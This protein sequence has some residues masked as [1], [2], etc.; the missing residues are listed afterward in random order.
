M[1]CPCN[2]QN[3]YANCCAI[4]HKNINQVKSAEQLMRS[5]YSAFAL[6][7]TEYLYKSHHST[8]RPSKKEHEEIKKWT[9]RVNWLK[10]DVLNSTEQTVHFKAY[11]MEN[12]Q[13]QV[14]EENSEFVMENGHWVYLGM[15]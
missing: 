2:P 12:G 14:I 10:L 5:R 11:Y 8:T 7:K 13:V 9:E 4:A 15:V 3:T 6:A 1:K